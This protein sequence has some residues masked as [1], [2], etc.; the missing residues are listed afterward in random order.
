[1]RLYNNLEKKYDSDF[2]PSMTMFDEY[3][4]GGMNGIV[5]QEMRERRSLAYSAGANVAAPSDLEHTYGIHGSIA[6]QNDKM[7]T[8]IE[9]FDEILNNMPQSEAAFQIAK[10]GLLASLRSNRLNGVA[11]INSYLSDE[12]KGLKESPRKMMFTKLQD[13]TLD[14]VV[15]FQQD[16]VKGRKYHYAILGDTKDLDLDALK[17]LGTVIVLTTD[18]IFG[19]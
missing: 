14:D 17:K 13:M 15:K 9:A 2:Q 1:M 12:K 6:T 16:V 5:F 8:A 19:Y 4:G 7:M 18:D 10:E 3:F 11:V